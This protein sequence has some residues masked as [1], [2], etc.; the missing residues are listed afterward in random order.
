MFSLPLKD[1]NFSLLFNARNKNLTAKLLKHVY[2]IMNFYNVSKHIC[3]H[4][5]LVSKH[6]VDLKHFLHHGLFEAAFYSNN[7][8]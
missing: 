1:L 5:E 8:I 6:R 3:R 4:F 7:T 2:G